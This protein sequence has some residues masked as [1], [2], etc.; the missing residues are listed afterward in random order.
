M[1]QKIHYL[2]FAIIFA[3]SFPAHAAYTWFE[4]ELTPV[5]GTADDLIGKAVATNGTWAIVGA[6]GDECVYVFKKDGSAWLQTQRLIAPDQTAG[7]NF[8]CSVAISGSN[9]IIGA[10]YDD[11]KGSNSGSAYIFTWNSSQSKW[12]YNTKLLASD[13]QANDLFGQSVAIS[14]DFTA[15]GADGENSNRGAVYMFQVSNWTQS[16]P[17][18]YSTPRVYPGHFGYSISMDEQNMIVGA[19]GENTNT[20]SVYLFSQD[21]YSWIGGTTKYQHYN[22]ATNDYFGCSVYIR[23]EKALAGAHGR[24]NG[25]IRCGAVYTLKP[26]TGQWQVGDYFTAPNPVS[27]GKFGYSVSFSGNRAIIGSPLEG[28]GTSYI[29]TYDGRDW[30]HQQR[31]TALD[32]AASDEF[33]GS[34]AIAGTIALVGANKGDGVIANSGSAYAFEYA[35]I[36][37][38]TLLN[39]NG[40]EKMAGLSKYNITWNSGG[41]IPTVALE[42]SINNGT[43]WITIA[44]VPNTGSYEWTVADA[45]SQQCRIK[46]SAG[47]ASDMSNNP[48]RIYPCSLAFDTNYDCVV[49]FE[50]FADFTSEWLLCGDPVD[51][52]CA[53]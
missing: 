19:Y 18:I 31:L 15:V 40:G 51:A 6:P 50:D 20:G 39:P 33:G 21:G 29:F 25:S 37:S 34:V 32:G 42:Y 12:L 45:N 41:T 53:P 4:H 30:N 38:L 27:G 35:E 28:F 48:F 44:S 16:T 49:D 17:I 26:V 7:D 9:I 24:S 43:S 2:L 52:N 46:V 13:G 36:T 5:Q 3:F 1:K 22:P 11:D 8:G 14:S 10:Y 23:G 47:A